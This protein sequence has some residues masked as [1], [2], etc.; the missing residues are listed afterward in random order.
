MSLRLSLV[1]LAGTLVVAACAEITTGP[2]SASG[3][4]QFTV[5][6]ALGAGDAVDLLLDGDTY[7]LPSPGTS[8]GLA[9]SS[10]THRLEAR[11]TGGQQ[12]AKASF[13]VAAGG[14]RTAVL[15][16]SGVSVALLV[17]AD[18]AS[19]PPQNAAKVRVVHSA[20][21]APVLDA[22]LFPT[23]AP[24]DSAARFVTPFT[25]GVGAN[26]QFPGYAVRSLG[27]YDVL[28]AAAG[29]TAP[30][31][32]TRVNLQNGQVWSVVLAWTG[33][34]TLELRPVLEGGQVLTQTR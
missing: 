19:L 12:L 16:G 22:Y 30:I 17:A 27:S 20:E 32:Q 10:G 24:V 25:Y 28:V 31:A 5:L 1:M 21:G 13:A 6:N 11:T 8:A 26:A 2:Q 14:R 9:I 34:H 3:D 29:T 23:G 15:A 7:P 4:A 33:Q 18:T